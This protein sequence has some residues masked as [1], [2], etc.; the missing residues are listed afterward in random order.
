MWACLEVSIEAAACNSEHEAE[1]AIKLEKRGAQPAVDY[2]EGLLQPPLCELKRR[3][4]QKD[5][6]IFTSRMSTK[7]FAADPGAER[8][9]GERNAG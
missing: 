3:G 1:V 6:S 7:P 4:V 9:H 8:E 5:R 2:A